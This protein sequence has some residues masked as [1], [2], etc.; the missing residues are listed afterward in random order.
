M[1]RIRKSRSGFTLIEMV[2]VIAIIVIL[3]CLVGFAVLG[4]INSA[5]DARDVVSSHNSAIESATSEIDSQT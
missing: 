5:R 4:Y 2:L 1:K 3:T